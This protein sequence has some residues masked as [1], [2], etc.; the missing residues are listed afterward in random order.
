MNYKSVKMTT[1]HETAVNFNPHTELKCKPWSCDWN[2]RKNSVFI[3]IL[4]NIQFNP[5]N[6]TWTDGLFRCLYIRMEDP[7]PVGGA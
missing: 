1:H 5:L 4:A 7:I 2:T 3:S 6:T